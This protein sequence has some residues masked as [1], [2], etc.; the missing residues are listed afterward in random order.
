MPLGFLAVFTQPNSSL[1]LEEFHQWYEEEHIP[2]RMNHLK[3][4]LSG[5]RYQASEPFQTDLGWLA[6]YEIDNTKT[7]SDPKYTSLREKRSEREKQVMA[8][9][10]K[11]VRILGEDSGVY[12]GSSKAGK[13]TGM[14]VGNP[15][16]WVV[17][18]AL[19]GQHLNAEDL[20]A[21]RDKLRESL[22]NS[23]IGMRVVK[24]LEK[25]EVGLGSVPVS[26]KS[27]KDEKEVEYLVIHDF[28]SEEGESKCTLHQ[29]QTALEGHCRVEEW[30]KWT[31]YKAYP[32]IA[33]EFI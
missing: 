26:S 27:E 17:T 20:V 12:D 2:I 32:G 18:H 19:Y 24:V 28:D 21:F 1:P 33:Q 10:E 25:A 6:M 11:L 5:A 16:R 13:S 31:L 23:W 14:K 9:L 22:G 29:V 30:R 3:E 15:T 4:F 7:F 8:R